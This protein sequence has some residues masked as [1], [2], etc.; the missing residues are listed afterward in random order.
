MFATVILAGGFGTRL[1]G[2][3]KDLPKPMAPVEGRPFVEWIARALHHQGIRDFV[4]STGYLAHKVEEHFHDGILPQARFVCVAESSPLGTAGGFLHAAA[5]SGFHPGSWLV[6]NGDSLVAAPLD[7]LLSLFADPEVDA[8]VLALWQE[9]ASR[10]GSLDT[11]TEGRLR[12]FREK[13]P[14]AAWINAGVYLF[15]SALL[16][17]FPTKNPLSFET[18]VFPGLIASGKN[19]RVARVEGEFL[20]IGLPESLARAGAFIQRNRSVLA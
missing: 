12:G 19:I 20:D 6:C 7:P 1:Q 17:E 4:L 13:K 10:Y 18:E 2:V 5:Q 14:G 3:L 8:G 16:M 9:D 15:R 11:D